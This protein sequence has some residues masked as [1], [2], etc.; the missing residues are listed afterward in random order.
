MTTV[1]GSGPGWTIGRNDS[2]SFCG[3]D[4]EIFRRLMLTVAASLQQLSTRPSG[5]GCYFCQIRSQRA[6]RKAFKEG[7]ED[8]L[9]TW[10][11]QAFASG[12]VKDVIDSYDTK[13][14]FLVFMKAPEHAFI[15]R[16]PFYREIL[17]DGKLVSSVRSTLGIDGN[18][19]LSNNLKI[20]AWCH[21]KLSKV[22]DKQQGGRCQ[23]CKCVV[24][25]GK[26]CQ[27]AHWP[28]HRKTCN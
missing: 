3:A 14:E 5:R 25:C 15:A 26:D 18:S 12:T 6:L 8:P 16:V 2:Q 22:A 17:N 9:L 20:C 7:E 19:F 27:R 24:Y 11:P 13:S 10:M 28:E 21:K 23:I 4:G 1:Y